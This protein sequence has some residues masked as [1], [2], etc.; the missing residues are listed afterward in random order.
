MI[1]PEFRPALLVVGLLAS[2]LHLR[3][4]RKVLLLFLFNLD[5]VC[6]AV[7]NLFLNITVSDRVSVPKKWR[8]KCTNTFSRLCDF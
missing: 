3:L 7:S 5:Q 4:V 6:S 8:A 1:Q 2:N